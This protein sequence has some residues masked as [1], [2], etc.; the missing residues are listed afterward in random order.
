VRLPEGKYEDLLT[1]AVHEK[2]MRLEKCAVRIL[3]SIGASP[4]DRL[5]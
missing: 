4:G 2:S 5:A 1:G 3:T